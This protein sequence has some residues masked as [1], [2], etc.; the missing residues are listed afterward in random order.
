[1]LNLCDILNIFKKL[2]SV[3]YSGDMHHMRF[4][5]EMGRIYAQLSQ[6]AKI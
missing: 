5:P 3:Q 4:E 6:P 1:M 2:N